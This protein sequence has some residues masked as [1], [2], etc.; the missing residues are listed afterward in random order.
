MLSA[1][2]CKKYA[3]K[4]HIW[5][6]PNAMEIACNNIKHN[7]YIQVVKDCQKQNQQATKQLNTQQFQK[8]KTIIQATCTKQQAKKKNYVYSKHSTNL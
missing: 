2:I 7:S 1:A 5:D 3:L 4:Y 8:H 6:K